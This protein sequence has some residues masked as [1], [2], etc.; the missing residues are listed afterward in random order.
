M[1]VVSL[2][3]LL[4]AAP[5][6]AQGAD[7]PSKDT[8]SQEIT[9]EEAKASSASESASEQD[10][11]A[12][13]EAKA[14]SA[15]ES[16]SEQDES[17]DEE[18]SEKEKNEALKNGA[19]DEP[20]DPAEGET[21]G[22]SELPTA[23]DNE[24][25]D[26]EAETTEGAP[27]SSRGKDLPSKIDAKT[28]DDDLDSE[29][30]VD[31]FDL[32]KIAWGVGLYYISGIN[33]LND[34]AG[35]DPFIDGSVSATYRVHDESYTVSQGATKFFL[36]NRD[37]EEVSVSD[38]SLSYSK[39]NWFSAWE[40]KVSLSVGFTL[41]ISEYSRTNGIL[42]QSRVSIPIGLTVLEAPFS[43][44]LSPGASYN[45]NFYKTTKSGRDDGGIP[46][47]HYRLG[48]SVSL[49]YSVNDQ[50][51]LGLSSGV[52]NTFYE[53]SSFSDAGRLPSQGYSLSFGANY[54]LMEQLSGDIGY[55]YGS[56]INRSFQEDF[57]LYDEQSST[58]SLGLSYS[59]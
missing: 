10:E 49:G 7:E 3:F 1:S 50:L 18:A 59:L 48:L 58:V 51:S 24:K 55:S 19:D 30:V 29:P 45:F 53:K 44:S 37:D 40:Q 14:S 38:T 6:F 47:A 2:L 8:A 41:P 36:I 27:L 46:L 11:S 21:S 32:A 4:A 23:R 17:A 28:A 20:A 31:G 57:Y 22:P 39:Q 16:A 12:D 52:S 15:P 25:I 26:G 43:L 42:S 34:R 33:V 56:T 35:P 54:Q 5:Q 13:E 9:D